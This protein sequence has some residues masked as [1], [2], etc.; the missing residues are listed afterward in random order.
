MS[1]RDQEAPGFSNSLRG[2]DRIQVDEYLARLREYVAQV[3]D[4]A[5]AAESA[6]VQCRRELASLPTNAGVSQRLA[7]ILQLANEEADE[8]RA[9]AQTE[10]EAT[11]HDAASEAE[12]T[13]NYAHQQ[14]D[15]VQREVDDLSAVREGLLQRLVDL[16]SEIRDAMEH[17]QAYLSGVA[18]TAHV[19]VELFDAE[20]IED[21]ATVETE[22]AADPDADTQMLTSTGQPPEH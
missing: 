7:A 15:A 16:G 1:I 11:T 21:D 6:L 20:A 2:Y 14:R 22:P 3:E 9:Q 13:V 17:Y 4:R 18:P 10:G 19:G 8:I 5:V 12:R